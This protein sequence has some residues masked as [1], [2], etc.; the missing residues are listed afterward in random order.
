MLKPDRLKRKRRI[1]SKMFGTKQSPRVT[2]YKSNSHIYVQVVD[3]EDGKTLV[4][5]SDVS[6]KS[7]GTK[8]QLAQLVGED[9]GK[10][11]KAAKIGQIVFDRSGYKYHGRVKA[12]AEGL[13]KA[14]LMV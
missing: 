1:R 14:G 9:L 6:L 3:D 5:S 12:I 8:T 13:R 7:K 4:S 2:V 10:K 11:A